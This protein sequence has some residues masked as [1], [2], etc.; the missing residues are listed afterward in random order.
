[1]IGAVHSSHSI[2]EAGDIGALRR[3]ARD[4]AGDAGLQ[5]EAIA[6]ADIVVT[7]LATN[8]IKHAGVV[9][10][11]LLGHTFINGIGALEVI[12]LDKGPGMQD[13]HRMLEDGVS[14]TGT[15]GGGL[16]AVIRLSDEFAI[17]SEK[18]CG[19]A[20]LSRLWSK[21][22]FQDWATDL[23]EF[24]G[25]TVAIKGEKVSG[26]RWAVKKCDGKFIVL[27]VDGLGHGPKAAEAAEEAVRV[28]LSAENSIPS[29]LLRIMHEAL[30]HTQ[31]AAAAVTLLDPRVNEAIYS[32]LGNISGR[33]VLADVGRSCVSIPGGL[34]FE[35]RKVHDFMY[36]WDKKSILLMHSDGIKSSIDCTGFGGHHPTLMSAVLYRDYGR[37]TDDTSVVMGRCHGSK[38]S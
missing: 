16:G 26:D 23:M 2:S 6:K 18:K 36:P 33:I 29:D 3:T 17:H 11:I 22:D 8:L 28:F 10:E 35:M 4:I 7:E 5:S 24:G 30:R 20:V 21:P 13:P 14:T 1:M 34:G 32:G 25:I 31:G 37:N 12:A 38:L 27:L 19:T 9:G 15:L